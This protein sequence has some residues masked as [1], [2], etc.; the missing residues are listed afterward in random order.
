MGRGV[1]TRYYAWVLQG[2]AYDLAVELREAEHLEE[3]QQAQDLE[4]P[5]VYLAVAHVCP[6]VDR[7]DGKLCMRRR[8]LLA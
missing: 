6:W 4:N 1:H 3:A 5:E 7:V 8:F 2:R